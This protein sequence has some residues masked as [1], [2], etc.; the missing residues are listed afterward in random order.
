MARIPIPAGPGE[1][2][3][4]GRV[5]FFAETD[6]DAAERSTREQPEG[7]ADMLRPAAPRE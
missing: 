4:P 6:V 7:P 1:P 3:V 2:A 5:L